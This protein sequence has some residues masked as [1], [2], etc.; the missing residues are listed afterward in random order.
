MK[1]RTALWLPWCLPWWLAGAAD[2]ATPWDEV[3]VVPRAQIVAALR[4][5][6][7]LGY[8]LEAI[9]NSVRLQT[10]VFLRLTDQERTDGTPPRALRVRQED[11]FQAFLDV[12]GLAAEAAPAWVRAPHRAGEDYLVDGRLDAIIDR[13]ATQAMPRRALAVKA[14]WPAAP[15]APS[16]YSFED[17]STDPAIETT[18][19]QV[20]GYRVL[21]YGNAIVVDGIHGVTGRATSGLL[22]LVFA[23]LGHAKAEQT[24][25]AMAPDGAQ[26]SRTTARKGMALTQS[27]VILPDGRVLAS[28]PDE[29]TD[30]VEIDERLARL[31]V[32]VAW[33]PQD[34]SPLP[35]LAAD[36]I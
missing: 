25:F 9:A 28:V 27:I 15:S 24:R 16:S 5:Q 3:R 34:L 13:A 6:A 2:A 20:N 36:A 8:R 17:W 33:R 35:A 10:G 23:L 4:E 11:W 29:R 1:R 19:R 30:W 32:N 12:T 7:S 14:G 18:R 31:A 21:D 26:I 22:G